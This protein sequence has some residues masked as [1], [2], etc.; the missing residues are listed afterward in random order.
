MTCVSS[1]HILIMIF[2]IE[3]E[4]CNQQSQEVTNMLQNTQAP[5]DQ[6]ELQQKCPNNNTHQQNHTCL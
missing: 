1:L 6:A 4:V 3:L 5:Q 2:H